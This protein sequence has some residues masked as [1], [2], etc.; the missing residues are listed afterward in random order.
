MSV[1]VPFRPDR[2]VLRANALRSVARAALHACRVAGKQPNGERHPWRDDAAIDGLLTRSAV[3]PTTLAATTA[4]QQVRVH[5]LPSLVP[6]SAAAAVLGQSLQ[7]GFDGA[8]S[9]SFPAVSLPTAGWIAESSSIPVL[10]GTT[11]SVTLTP[12][13]IAAILVLTR[14]MISG[15]DAE[16]VMEQ[17]L[18][19]NIGASLD[20]VFFNANAASA[21]VSPAGILNGAISVTPAASGSGAIVTDVSKLIAAVAPV[22][23]GSPVHLVAAP[24]QAAAIKA[25]LIDPPPTYASNALADKTVV[26]IVPSAIASANGTPLISASLETTLHMASP[27]SE[28]V[29]S[30]STVAAP[31]RS[32]F[33]T[34]SLALRYTQ[35]LSWMKRGAG[36]AICSSVN[37]P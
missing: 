7:F 28:L 17:V 29:A 10:Q 36:V 33:Q 24:A 1:P 8:A 4:L 13:K 5:F 18:R 34:D 16:T 22:S 21:G 30:P 11:S 25:T 6:V 27:A 31:Q 20:A 2:R 9:L 32:M 37:W 19:E 12:F 14:E 15:A 3:S 23:G 26:A 35:E